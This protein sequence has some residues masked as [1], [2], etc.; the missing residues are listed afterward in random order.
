MFWFFHMRYFKW[1][2]EKRQHTFIFGFVMK[3]KIKNKQQMTN[4]KQKNSNKQNP[5]EI[6]TVT[7]K[8]SI[9]SEPVWSHK[10]TGLNFQVFPIFHWERKMPKITSRVAIKWKLVCFLFISNWFHLV[11]DGIH[12]I[13]TGHMIC[14]SPFKRYFGY[15]QTWKL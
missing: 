15:K 4:K 3:K 7:T 1:G 12:W 2:K 10:W 8:L 14:L 11:D 5:C 13:Q 9:N 6:F